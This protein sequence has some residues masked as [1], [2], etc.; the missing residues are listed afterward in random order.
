VL[1]EFE[2]G[3]RIG[4]VLV[5]EGRH[6]EGWTHFAYELH[7]T[8]NFL[9]SRQVGDC[10]KE[11]NAILVT[12]RILCSSPSGDASFVGGAFWDSFGAV[13]KNSELVVRLL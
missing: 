5:P 7:S 12:E 9:R 4:S 6:G 8:K 2:G 3:R 10:R 13:H 11:P 1:E